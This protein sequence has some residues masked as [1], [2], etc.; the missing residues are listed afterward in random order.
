MM[1][2]DIVLESNWTLRSSVDL[3]HDSAADDTAT[4]GSVQLRYSF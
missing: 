1:S 3:R 2:L 4:Q